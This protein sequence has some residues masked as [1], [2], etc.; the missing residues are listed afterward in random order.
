[1]YHSYSDQCQAGLDE[2]QIASVKKAKSTML[3]HIW[4]VLIRSNLC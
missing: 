2:I 1:M 3:F 4:I